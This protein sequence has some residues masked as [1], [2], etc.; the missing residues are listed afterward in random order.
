MS[1]TRILYVIASANIG[2]AERFVYTLLESLNNGKFEK[3]VVCPA[4]GYYAERFK[5]LTKDALFIS[6]KRSFINLGTILRVA[7]FI[8]ANNIDIVHTMLYTSDFCGIVAGLLSGRCCVL[9]TINGFNFLVLKRD[10]VRLKR[11]LASFVYRFIYRYSHKLVAVS[12]AVKKDLLERR[13]IKVDPKKIEAVLAAG[14]DTAYHNF[15]E[16]D[17]ERLRTN[18]LKGKEL[19]ISAIGALDQIKDYDNMLEAFSLAADKSSKVK[20]LIAGDGPEKE[21]LQSKVLALGLE[22]RVYFLGGLEEKKRNAL[23]YL[24]D[25]F[26]NSSESEGCP[27]SLLEAMYFEK[28]I[29]AT[30][31]GGIPE[32]IKH[33]ESGLLVPPKRP[34]QLAEAILDLAKN[35]KIRMQL[36]RG[37][38]QAFEQR[39]TKGQML[40]AYENIYDSLM[41]Q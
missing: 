16:E 37:A 35:P 25:I 21:H 18:Y 39:F 41:R 38:K 8:K 28:P 32:I 6:A 13:G 33:S 7:R 5:P 1:K 36:G 20:L 27:T 9:N 10:G 4:R 40:Q 19:A 30:A 23:L 14:T 12:E 15:S 24:T 11:R 34:R 26:I 29:I 17:V 22:K 31:A 3:Y 2:G